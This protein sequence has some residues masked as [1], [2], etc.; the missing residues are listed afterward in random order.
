M[1]AKADRTMEYLIEMRQLTSDTKDIVKGIHDSVIQLND[2]NILHAS[3]IEKYSE[4]T[5]KELAEFRK[6][7]EL[8]ISK[9]WYLLLGLMAI[10]L[11]IMGYKEIVSF[12]PI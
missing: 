10:I 11:V 1:S 9:G 7:I 12:L 4:T 2:A 3:N 5:Q 6:T 8:L